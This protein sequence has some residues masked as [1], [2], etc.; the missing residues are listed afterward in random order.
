[1]KA[2]RI[3]PVVALTLLAS[4]AGIQ[5]TH[6]YEWNQVAQKTIDSSVLIE[7]AF[8]MPHPIIPGET[9]QATGIGT[10]AVLSSDGWIMTNAHVI[11]DDNN[12]L[13]EKITVKFADERIFAV[14]KLYAFPQYD[15][16]L[17]KI[18]AYNLDFIKVR[19]KKV[20]VGEPC[21]A[22][23][24]PV[25]YQFVVKEG[26]ISQPVFNP[27]ISPRE[28]ALMDGEEESKIIHI[29]HSGTI[30]PGNSGG[31]LVDVDGLLIGINNAY[32]PR[33]PIY[34][35]AISMQTALDVLDIVSSIVK[36]KI[37]TLA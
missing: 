29:A 30:M 1:M 22:V 13:S 20:E 21:L 23:G 9:Y 11:M 15:I 16:A 4:C 25:P 33:K 36:H 2:T 6:T 14:E 17:L 37:Y 31:P 10:G 27:Y 5:K 18:N 35:L 26:I 24:N 8:E 7:A 28:R 19:M 3:L 34:G 32:I 12:G